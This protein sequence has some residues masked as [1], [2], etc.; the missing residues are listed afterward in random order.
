MGGCVGLP[1][2]QIG[3][4]VFAQKLPCQY[5]IF[6]NLPANKAQTSANIKAPK[7]PC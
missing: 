3:G 2:R 6:T 7:N 5:Q 1:P 4:G